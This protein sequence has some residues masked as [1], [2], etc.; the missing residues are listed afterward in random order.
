MM[1]PKDADLSRRWRALL[2]Q[3]ETP[4]DEHDLAAWCDLLGKSDD[5]LGGVV[6]LYARGQGEAGRTASQALAPFLALSEAASWGPERSTARVLTALAADAHAVGVA[7]RLHRRRMRR[8]RDKLPV[9]MLPSGDILLCLVGPL[10]PEVMDAVFAR[11]FTLAVGAD[12]PD[13]V[14]DTSGLEPSDDELL[15]AT[16]EGF[17]RHELAG[18]LRLHLTGQ[19]EE[20]WSRRLKQRGISGEHVRC[21]ARLQDLPRS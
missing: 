4:V 19:D 20:G 3:T 5:E 16:L 14:I 12:Y 15:L 13:V 18:R 2:A 21:L 11:A 6:A 8:M 7:T 1:L 10:E 17:P 9:L